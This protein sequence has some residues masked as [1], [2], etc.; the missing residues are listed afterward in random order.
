MPRLRA[1]IC[2]VGAS[3]QQLLQNLAILAIL[4]SVWTHGLDRIDGKARWYRDAFGV[5][6]S[7]AGVILLMQVPLEIGPGI[8]VDLRGALIALACLLYTSPSP[9][10]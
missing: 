1:G 6:L 10:D 3:W 9:R 8:F 4:V 2:I 5:G 7:A